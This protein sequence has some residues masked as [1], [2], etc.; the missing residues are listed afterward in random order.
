MK[1]GDIKYYDVINGIGVRVSIFVSGC[2]HHCE[3]CFNKETW[4]DTYGEEFDAN[5]ENNIFQY[6]SKYNSVIKGISILGGDPTYS[7]NI[8]PLSDF[9]DRFKDKFPTKDIWIWSGY[10]WEKILK[11]KD[12]YELISKCDVLIDGIFVEKLKNIKLKF[13]GSSNQRVIDIKKSI[14]NNKVEIFID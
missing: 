5:V 7:K 12:M 13:R 2:S 3:H 8:K 4:D 10:T 1:Y 11:D 6:I 14:A 9:I